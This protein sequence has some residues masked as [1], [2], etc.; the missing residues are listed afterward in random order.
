L[1]DELHLE[2]PSGVRSEI[3]DIKIDVSKV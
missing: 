2:R 3:S 1:E